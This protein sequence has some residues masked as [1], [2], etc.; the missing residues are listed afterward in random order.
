MFS[1]ILPT[2]VRGSESAAMCGVTV[3]PGCAQ[4]GLSAGS[5]S[6]LEHVQVGVREVAG[7]ERR[8]QVGDDDVA[9]AREVD[10]AAVLLDRVK[11]FLNSRF[12]WFLP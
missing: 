12:P 3:M 8:E 9:A 11:V 10:E 2:E 1:A 6:G 7:V 5:G 4:S